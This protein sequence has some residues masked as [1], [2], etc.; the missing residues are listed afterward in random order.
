MPG[1]DDQPLDD[2]ESDHVG[3]EREEDNPRAHEFARERA[4]RP[5]ARAVLMKISSSDRPLCAALM[6]ASGALSTIV[7]CLSI[8][9]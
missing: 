2:V 1:P 8:V 3:G 4:S 5:H 9:T 7:P 6:S